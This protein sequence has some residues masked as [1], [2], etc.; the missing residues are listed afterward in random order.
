[1][2]YLD[3]TTRKLQ[4]YLAGA[5]TTT[6]PQ[7]TVFYY[8][9]PSQTKPSFE[10]YR[11]AMYEEE[12]SGATP[13]DVCPAPLANGVTRNIQHICVHNKDTVAA[14]VT[15]VIDDGGVDRFLK[16]STLNANQS[17]VYEHGQGW[18]VL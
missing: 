17:L 11:G 10:E 14:T 18:Q 5:V 2:I 3:R 12:T 16:T 9:V 8:D 13:V 7:V 4:A 15:I 6:Q 1:M